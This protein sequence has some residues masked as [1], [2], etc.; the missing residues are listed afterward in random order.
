MLLFQRQCGSTSM[1]EIAHY[2][3]VPRVVLIMR[4]FLIRCC[5]VCLSCAVITVISADRR[6]S[7][8]K[9]A[10]Q[11]LV[12]CC[13]PFIADERL[14]NNNCRVFF[15]KLFKQ[16]ECLEGEIYG[17]CRENVA[18]TNGAISKDGRVNGWL[19]WD[20]KRRSQWGRPFQRIVIKCNECIQE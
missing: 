2:E 16:R 1:N 7:F 20:D 14:D 8:P 18:Q 10:R 4:T 5:V 3:T 6:T 9:W 12:V 13:C 17:L 19:D 11:K 15:L